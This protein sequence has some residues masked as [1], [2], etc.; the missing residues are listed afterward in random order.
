AYRGEPFEIRKTIEDQ[1]VVDLGDRK[2]E[3][4]LTPGH[5]PDALCLLDR[6]NRLLFTGDTFYPAALYAHL[7]GSDLEAYRKTAARLAELR[8]QVDFVL[9]AHNEPLVSSEYLTRMRD[10]FEAIAAS[11][12]DFVLTDGNREYAFEG[13]SILTPNPPS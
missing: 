11:R 13:F 9:P 12:A 7:P 5:A 3:I 4:L 6:E 8:D 10:A 1:D 2:L